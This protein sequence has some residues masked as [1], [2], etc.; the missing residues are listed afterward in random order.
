MVD[1]MHEYP[2]LTCCGTRIFMDDVMDDY[3]R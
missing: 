1:A 2:R 3:P